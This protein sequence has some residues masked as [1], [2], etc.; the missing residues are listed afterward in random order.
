MTLLDG[1]EVVLSGTADVGAQ[2]RGL[3]VDDPRYGRVLISWDTFERVDFSSGGRGRAYADFAPGRPLMG[4]VTT[5]SGRRLA[6]RLVFDLDES[7]TTETL[8]APSRGVDYMIPFDLVQSIVLPELDDDGEGPALVGVSLATG[9]DVRLER[10]GDLGQ[11]NAGMLIFSEGSQRA[12]YVPWSEVRR[13]VFEGHVA[14]SN[15][16]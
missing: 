11:L 1:R 15:G 13:V 6:G 10:A 5:R 14:A 7:E 2:N 12:E 8:D 4:S 3:Y 9:A 16:R